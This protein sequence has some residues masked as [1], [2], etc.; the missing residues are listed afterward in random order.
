M[1]VNEG[2]RK[3]GEAIV[4]SES[5]DVCLTPMGPKMVPVP[6]DILG[7]FS[8]AQLTTSTVAFRGCQAFT[9]ISYIQGVTGNEAGS[10][11]GIKTGVFSGGGV[12]SPVQGTESQFV[13]AEKNLVLYHTSLMQMNGPAWGAGNTVGRVMYLSSSSTVSA[14]ENGKVNG[15]TNPK[16]KA[17]TE[18]EKKKEDGYEAEAKRETKIDQGDR[19]KTYKTGPKKPG[20]GAPKVERTTE[21]K[22]KKTFDESAFQ[23]DD[24][25]VKLGNV[26]GERY[27]GAG[28]DHAEGA[29]KAGIG[30]G[31][32]FT[33]LKATA[34]GSAA[35]GLLN[36]NVQAELL[37][38]KAEAGIEAT[39]GKGTA[40]IEGKLGAEVVVAEASA[41]GSVKITGKTLWDNLVGPV[42]KAIPRNVPNP[43]LQYAE[44]P[45]S[46]DKGIEIGAEGTI[47]VGAAASVSGKAGYDK[48]APPGKRR[49]GISGGA[50]LGLGPKVGLKG[51]LNILF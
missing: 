14:D 20:D 45:A 16:Q 38:A 15:D 36:G 40:A 43:L 25:S 23:T 28:Y 21:V 8:D 19:A 33:T 2:V 51:F 6:Y 29:Y 3:T 9:T 30:A 27:F 13:K 10:G 7:R 42:I 32:S 50:K 37:S 39:L 34:Q 35:N 24:G 17:E 5:P 49:A 26:T 12:C 18:A 4:V 31:G 44:A 46:W 1:A 11:G 41:Q 22:F 48:N 47:G